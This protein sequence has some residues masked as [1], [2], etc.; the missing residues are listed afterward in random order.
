[1][2]SREMLHYWTAV[3]QGL[4]QA[5]SQFS[6]TELHFK[7]AQDLWSLGKVVLH[8]ADTEVGWFEYVVQRK[9]MDWP[10]DSRL[11]EYPKMKDIQGRLLEVHSRTEAF[12]EPLSEADLDQ[13]I[14]APWGSQFPLHFVL[15]HVLEHEI[16]HRGEI[17][18][19]LGLLGREAPDV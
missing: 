18:L 10:P 12:L 16:H 8:I 13:V 17:Y 9:V 7:P 2:K 3:R 1:M 4:N 5:L 11:S 15:W 19:M 14:Q 6:D